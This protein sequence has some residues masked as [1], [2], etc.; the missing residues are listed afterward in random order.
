MDH[1]HEAWL[2]E[3]SQAPAVLFR[4][5]ADPVRRRILERLVAGPAAAGELARRMALPRVNISHHLSVLAAAGLIEQRQRQ[6]AVKPEALTRLRRYFDLA[7][8]TAAISRP[9]AARPVAHVT[10]P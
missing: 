6:A 1:P 9:D 5:L 4:A 2:G 10:Q 3:A 7:L 8:T